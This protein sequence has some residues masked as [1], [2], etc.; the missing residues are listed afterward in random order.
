MFRSTD[1][2][3]PMPPVSIR[4]R[5]VRRVAT[6]SLAGRQVSRSRAE[7]KDSEARERLGVPVNS[8]HQINA[9]SE[10]MNCK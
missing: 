7:G 4:W 1:S 10:S 3:P 8:L 2:A 6:G 9:A 5:I